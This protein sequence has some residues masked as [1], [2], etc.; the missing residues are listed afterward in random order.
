MGSQ[1]TNF[2]LVQLAGDRLDI[3]VRLDQAPSLESS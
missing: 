2:G 1:Q 3:V